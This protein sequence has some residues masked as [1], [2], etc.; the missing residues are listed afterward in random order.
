MLEVAH[1]PFLYYYGCMSAAKKAQALE[2]F[3]EES[4]IAP[5][6][7]VRAPLQATSSEGSR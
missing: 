5:R 6:V 7:M 1:I 2:I 4:H 3:K